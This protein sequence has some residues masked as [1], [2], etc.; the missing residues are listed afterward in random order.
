MSVGD[1]VSSG[2]NELGRDGG[3]VFED[4][5]ECWVVVGEV[6]GRNG[7]VIVGDKVELNG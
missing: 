4:D 3:V 7:D 5:W 6:F 2:N 1:L